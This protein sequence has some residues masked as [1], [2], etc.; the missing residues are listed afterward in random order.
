MEKLLP[1]PQGWSKSALYRI[2]HGLLLEVQGGAGAEMGMVGMAISGFW[3][4][5]YLRPIE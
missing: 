5:T 2:R 3:H 4:G 1:A